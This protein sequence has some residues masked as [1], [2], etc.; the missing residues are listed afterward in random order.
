MPGFTTESGKFI[1]PLS[2]KMTYANSADRCDGQEFTVL[3]RPRHG[4]HGRF[5]GAFHI[6]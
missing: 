6:F 2:E 3:F 5:C 4:V 1:M